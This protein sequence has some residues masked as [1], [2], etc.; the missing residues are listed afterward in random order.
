MSA[1]ATGTTLGRFY[2]HARRLAFHQQSADGP[3]G[4]LL[5]GAGE[6][7]LGGGVLKIPDDD[8]SGYGMSEPT[9]H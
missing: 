1:F 7:E 3:G 4:N 5:G 6:E 8:L 2:F 9:A